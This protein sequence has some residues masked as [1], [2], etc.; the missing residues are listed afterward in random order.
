MEFLKKPN[1]L[2]ICFSFSFVIRENWVVIAL[3]SNAMMDSQKNICW[4]IIKLRVVIERKTKNNIACKQVL[5][6]KS[7]NCNFDNRSESAGKELIYQ[8]LWDISTTK[9]WY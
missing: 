5:Y 7:V 1:M 9:S 8:H 6:I 3:L 4:I 2:K